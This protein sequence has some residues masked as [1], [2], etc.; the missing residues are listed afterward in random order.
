MVE[1]SLQIVTANCHLMEMLLTMDTIQEIAVES[2]SSGYWFNFLQ[3]TSRALGEKS[4]KLGGTISLPYL[5]LC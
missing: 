5:P 4:C 3:F 2:H 1:P